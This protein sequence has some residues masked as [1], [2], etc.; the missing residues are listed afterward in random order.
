MIEPWCNA[1]IPIPVSAVF[2]A[3]H[4]AHAARKKGLARE[5]GFPCKIYTLY[6]TLYSELR[7]TQLF[8]RH[9]MHGP[10]VSL[11]ILAVG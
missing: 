7:G 4:P 1:L 9:W 8:F 2:M 3:F 6:T 11:F 5:S 10:L